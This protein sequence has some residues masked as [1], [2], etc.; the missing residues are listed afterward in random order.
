MSWA[1]AGGIVFLIGSECEWTPCLIVWWKCVDHV[2]MCESVRLSRLNTMGVCTEH[3][4]IKIVLIAHA[5]FRTRACAYVDLEAWC[6][7]KWDLEPWDRNSK[8]MGTNGLGRPR[9]SICMHNSSLQ[10]I[11]GQP[12]SQLCNVTSAQTWTA[13]QESTR[14]C[15]VR[16]RQGPQ[17]SKT[18]AEWAELGKDRQEHHEKRQG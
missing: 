10:T 13:D 7:L 9:N 8:G 6:R 15:Q 16:Q 3:V 12:S 5:Q 14:Y 18:D 2:S 17:V 1:K 11:Q 4:V